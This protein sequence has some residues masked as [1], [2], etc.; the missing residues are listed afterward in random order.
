MNVIEQRIKLTNLERNLQ[1]LCFTLDDKKPKPYHGDMNS[2]LMER[3]KAD[4]S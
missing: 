1:F 2:K 3:L 4:K